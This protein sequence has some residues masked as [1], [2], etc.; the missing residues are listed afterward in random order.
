MTMLE[1]I[2]NRRNQLI[3]DVED[4]PS[5]VMQQ[6]KRNYDMDAQNKAA[7]AGSGGDYRAMRQ[8]SDQMSVADANLMG[9]TASARNQENL[10]RLGAKAGLLSE[11]AKN[12]MQQYALSTG[13]GNSFLPA[14]QASGSA[15]QGL[16][17]AGQL[18]LAGAGQT[19]RQA[20]GWGGMGNMSARTGMGASMGILGSLNQERALNLE[21]EKFDFQRVMAPIS[22]ITGLGG[23]LLKSFGGGSSQT[24]G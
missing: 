13:E 9:A 12:A 3:K 15:L 5:S 7:M 4:A 18:S 22:A 17:G 16:L 20:L 11:N 10:S 21:R 19:G 24:P 8:Y 23:E 2:Q 1:A 6:A 14:M